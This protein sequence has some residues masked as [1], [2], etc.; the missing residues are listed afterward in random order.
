MFSSLDV[1]N[2]YWQINVRASNRKI[3]A[4]SCPQGT[5]PFRRMPM[6]TKNSAFTFQMVISHILHGV[7]DFTFANI[8]DILIFSRNLQEHKNHLYHVLHRLNVY[9]LSFNVR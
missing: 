7:E 2:A 6:G 3:T 9:S 8:D 4:F 1:K 5:F